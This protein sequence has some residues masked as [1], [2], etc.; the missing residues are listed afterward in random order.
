MHAGDSPYDTLN[1]VDI[2]SLRFDE[3]DRDSIDDQFDEISHL[4][5]RDGGCFDP[6]QC[7]QLVSAKSASPDYP[8]MREETISIIARAL[9][10]LPENEVVALSLSF[11]GERPLAEVGEALGVSQSRACQIK[12]NAI[13]KLREQLGLLEHLR[14]ALTDA[15]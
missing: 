3:D 14:D 10:R 11:F 1:F 12:K 9:D 4:V 13:R 7:A 8:M 2:D 6:N 15:I 5:S